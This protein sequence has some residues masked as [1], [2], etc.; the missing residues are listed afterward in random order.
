VLVSSRS[1]EP[2]SG[3][4]AR[5]WAPIWHQTRSP[6]HRGRSRLERYRDTNST[7]AVCAS[8]A[9]VWGRRVAC[10]HPDV[11]TCA[12][13]VG[14]HDHIVDRDPRRVGVSAQGDRRAAPRARVVGHHGRV[15]GSAGS[16]RPK[17]R[18]SAAPRAAPPRGEPR[19]ARAPLQR[20][21]RHA[22]LTHRITRDRA[23]NVMRIR[24]RS[25]AR[26]APHELTTAGRVDTELP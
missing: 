8:D 4:T 2:P 10:G 16:H 7:F 14:R 11:E 5:R 6:R 23:Q 26:Y 18:Q 22:A 1:S 3:L 25:G 15:T 12:L 20:R 24:D 19:T 21:S 17:A 9:T 13:L